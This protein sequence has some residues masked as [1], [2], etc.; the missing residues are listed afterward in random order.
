MQLKKE[1]IVTM[2]NTIEALTNQVV[3]LCDKT[4]GSIENTGEAKLVAIT[5]IAQELKEE[6]ERI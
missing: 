5:K 3:A 6:N 2:K 4:T 1:E